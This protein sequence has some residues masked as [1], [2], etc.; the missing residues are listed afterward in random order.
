MTNQEDKLAVMYSRASELAEKAKTSDPDKV[1]TRQISLGSKA[2]TPFLSG[3]FG[4]IAAGGRHTQYR[5]RSEPPDVISVWDIGQLDDRLKEYFAA[6]ATSEG[7]ALKE[8]ANKTV[9]TLHLDEN[10][11]LYVS[12][13]LASDMHAGGAKAFRA[14]SVEEMLSSTAAELVDGWVTLFT[15][16]IADQCDNWKAYSGAA[17]PAR[18]SGVVSRIY[19]LVG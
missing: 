1:N 11:G 2:S 17:E 4:M 9:K 6:R 5:L 18:S 15:A 3:L 16:H 14:T 10:G 19:S 7:E 12:E 8:A 13:T